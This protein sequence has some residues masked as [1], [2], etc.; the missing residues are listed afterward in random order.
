MAHLVFLSYASEDKAVAS[1][2]LRA[3]EGAG[4]GCWMAP[5]DVVPGTPYP[6]AILEAIQS[7]R[8]LVL[9]FSAHS[10]AS[11]QVLREVERAV[12]KGL[13][14][15]PYRIQDLP[16]SG[17]MEYLIGTTH[18]LDAFAM[19]EDAG[20]QALVAAVREGLAGAPPS[21][22]RPHAA[23]RAR[24]QWRPALAAAARGAVL[25][26]VLFGTLQASL[27]AISGRSEPLGLL[28]A[29]L[30]ALLLGLA[31][32]LTA[33]LASA[34]LSRVL[35]S[36]FLAPVLARGAGGTLAGAVVEALSAAGLW[37]LCPAAGGV[38][39]VVAALARR[40]TAAVVAASCVGGYFG[41]L[42]W[43]T[44]PELLGG[45]NLGIALPVA[46]ML[47]GSVAAALAGTDPA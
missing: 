4:V 29:A 13:A 24:W 12:S 3:L 18:W 21:P 41:Y 28:G 8:L 35:G 25:A 22:P 31:T 19:E 39:G 11:P 42:L 7:S 2:V 37:G 16:P 14:V 5:R 26:T 46:G 23:T 40:R 44:Q 32:G 43:R 27:A 36:S 6:L 45:P 17:A 10:D 38:G 33:D 30:Y 9:V 34:W 1:G 15:I 20:L 47:A